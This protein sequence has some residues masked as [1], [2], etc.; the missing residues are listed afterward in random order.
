M[1]LNTKNYTVINYLIEALN[2]K[3]IYRLDVKKRNKSV[4]NITVFVRHKMHTKAIYD[5]IY[6]NAYNRKEMLVS[7][8]KLH[9]D[10]MFIECYNNV[11][12]RIK[13]R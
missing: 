13:V 6:A 2:N 1:I 12:Y 10:Y 4:I 3:Y 7:N 9:T 8:I 11:K 5:M